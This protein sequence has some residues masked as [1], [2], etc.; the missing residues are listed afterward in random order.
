MLASQ[1]TF[2]PVTCE[3]TGGRA[4]SGGGQS[5]PAH[6]RLYQVRGARVTPCFAGHRPSLLLRD[7]PS[8]LLRHSSI[9]PR[10][11]PSLAGIARLSS[12]RARAPHS[13]LSL[14]GARL[15]PQR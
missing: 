12:Y 1:C 2:T 11:G 5:V 7:H 6:E 4:G 14:R 10:A 15:Y 3:Y 13:R 9:L 8:L